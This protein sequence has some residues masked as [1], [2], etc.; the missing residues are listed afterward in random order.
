MEFIFAVAVLTIVYF[1]I[2]KVRGP[3]PP[4]EPRYGGAPYDEETKTNPNAE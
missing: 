1:V 4:S 3:L 2:K